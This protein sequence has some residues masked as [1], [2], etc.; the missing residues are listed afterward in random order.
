[1]IH[2]KNIYIVTQY[3]FIQYSTYSNNKELGMSYIIY[4]PI[5]YHFTIILDNFCRICI[6]LQ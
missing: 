5:K 1:M 4:V 6:N 2:Y 3:T